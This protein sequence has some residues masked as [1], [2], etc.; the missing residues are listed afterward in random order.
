MINTKGMI[1]ILKNKVDIFIWSLFFYTSNVYYTGEIRLKYFYFVSLILLLF[2]IYIR[3]EKIQAPQKINKTLLLLWSL[4][5]I[6]IFL[7]ALIHKDRILDSILLVTIV[8]YFFISKIRTY[9]N[10]SKILLKSLFYSSMLLVLNAFS[11]LNIFNVSVQIQTNSVGIFLLLL[12]IYIFYKYYYNNYYFV[13]IIINLLL[14]V[15]TNSRT[16]LVAFVICFLVVLYLKMKSEFG[17]K[18]IIKIISIITLLLVFIA[19]VIQFK[20]QFFKIE[21]MKKFLI[22]SSQNDVFNGRGLI[23]K[24]IWNNINFTGHNITEIYNTFGLSPHSNYMGILFSSGILAFITFILINIIFIMK[25]RNNVFD[26]SVFYLL[27]VI[28]FVLSSVSEYYFGSLNISL[29]TLWYISIG[30]M[31]YGKE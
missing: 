22:Y 11:L 4:F 6:S 9:P 2:L 20:D 18:A 12:S 10:L 17:L 23:W 31:I 21:I 25:F 13:A 30:K 24:Y 29:M 8:P 16:S 1:S 27:V 5:S 14:I 28:M 19:L 26:D 3:A 7:T 15:L